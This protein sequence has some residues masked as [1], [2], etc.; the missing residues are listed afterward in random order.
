MLWFEL[1]KHFDFIVFRQ[2]P[3]FFTVDE[4]CLNILWLSRNS[5]T[6]CNKQL[7]LSFTLSLFQAMPQV[8]N[9]VVFMQWI[10]FFMVDI[11]LVMI[12]NNQPHI[13]TTMF[14]NICNLIN[15]Q[16]KPSNLIKLESLNNRF[17]ERIIMFICFTK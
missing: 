14:S 11:V 17:D 15:S 3:T 1:A 13:F 6:I 7:R 4:L 10:S 8:V 9:S 12:S 5:Y 16:I 2:G